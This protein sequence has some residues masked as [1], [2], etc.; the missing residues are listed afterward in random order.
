MAPSSLAHQ[1]FTTTYKALK[2]PH[3]QWETVLLIPRFRPL[4]EAAKVIPE[5]FI[6]DENFNYKK[7]LVEGNVAKDNETVHTSNLHA[8]LDKNEASDDTIQC[9]PLTFDPTATG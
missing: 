7:P 6:A 8:P 2:A 5:I 4:R 9:G 3:F 1:A